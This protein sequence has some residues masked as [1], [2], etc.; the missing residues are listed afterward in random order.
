ML[1]AS[2]NDVR[3]RLSP[4][5]ISDLAQRWRT[6]YPLFGGTFALRLLD[7]APW[8]AG[9][10]A[11]ATGQADGAPPILVIGTAADPRGPQD[12]SRRTAD[13]LASA[14]FLGWQGSGTGA[15]PRTPCVSA[16]V[17]AMLVDGII[18]Q[19]GTLCPP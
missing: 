10:P 13:S 3:R 8:P 15:Y 6:T 11:P 19:A 4:G 17:D 18:P 2:C 7:C 9:G 12:G 16:V 1:A 5:E 14:R